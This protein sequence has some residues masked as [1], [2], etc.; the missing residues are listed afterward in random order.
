MSGICAIWRADNPARVAKTLASAGR[1]LVLADGERIT[2]KTHQAAGLVVSAAYETQ[3][4][5]EDDQVLLACDADLYGTET[6]PEMSNMAALLAR[7]YAQYGSGFIEKLRGG[8][9]LVLWDKR[10]QKLIAAVDGF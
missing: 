4:I 10:E 8:F 2:Q 3:Q 9:S 6:P 7:M 5:F 1:G